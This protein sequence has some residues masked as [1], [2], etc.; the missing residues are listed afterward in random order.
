[1]SLAGLSSQDCGRLKA[2]WQSF[3]K[4]FAPEN[5]T[6]YADFG[7]VDLSETLLN[8]ESLTRAEQDRLDLIS[9]EKRRREFQGS[10]A[11]ESRFRA[12]APSGSAVLTSI[13]H[14]GDFVFGVATN[15]VLAG[16]GI[17]VEFSNRVLP[18][19]LRARICPEAGEAFE[20]LS[21]LDIWVI[22]EA[23]FKANP[24]NQGTVI[25][26]YRLRSYENATQRGASKIGSLTSPEILF[27]LKHVG[28]L[29][30]AFAIA[31]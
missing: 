1:M 15:M 30:V 5:G 19:E 21:T 27:Q 26:H 20:S 3:S 12:Q 16:I 4:D 7:T 25:P 23:V 28:G 10:R 17:D 9:G 2:I 29:T 24:G 22:K 14:T 6:C 8:P 31:R 13:S 11:L 18:P